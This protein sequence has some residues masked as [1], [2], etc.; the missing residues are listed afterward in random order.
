MI[1]KNAKDLFTIHQNISVLKYQFRFYLDNLFVFI[2]Q[3]AIE[4]VTLICLSILLSNNS[5]DCIGALYNFLIFF[6]N[7]VWFMLT[8]DQINF[9]LKL[10]QK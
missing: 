3:A 5:S 8:R 1:I 10:N 7:F 4:T 9:K 6:L 2:E